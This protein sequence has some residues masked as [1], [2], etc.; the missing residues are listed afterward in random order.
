M[1]FASFDLHQNRRRLTSNTV[2]GPTYTTNT[3]IAAW[4][5][6][7]D[8]DQRDQC[9]ID[10]SSRAIADRDRGGGNALDG[11]SH[12]GLRIADCGLIDDLGKSAFR[13]P[14]SAIRSAGGFKRVSS[15]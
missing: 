8:A 5:A 7:F 1:R 13:N 14:R 2:T 15:R 6:A 4:D 12:W 3:C 9:A 11:G 10:A